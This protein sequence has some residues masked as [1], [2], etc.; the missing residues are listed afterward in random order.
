VIREVSGRR[1]PLILCAACWCA[2]RTAPT[3]H[4]SSVSGDPLP[5]DPLWDAFDSDWLREGA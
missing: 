1:Q 3:L 5:G 2:P 4:F